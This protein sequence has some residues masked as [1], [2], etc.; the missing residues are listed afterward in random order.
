MAC[1]CSKKMFVEA[2]EVHVKT[3]ANYKVLY[4]YEDTA[5]IKMLTNSYRKNLWF[6]AYD[7]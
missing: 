6:K 5:N 2:E 1:F 3:Q 4:P 7:P